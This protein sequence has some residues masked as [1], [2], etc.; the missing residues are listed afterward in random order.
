MPEI[1]ILEIRADLLPK[2]KAFMRQ[3]LIAD[4]AHFG[5]TPHDD[6]H[7][8]FPTEGTEDSFT[9]AAY[10]GDNMAGVVSFRRNG[11]DREKLRH[12]GDLFRMYVSPKYR[13]KGISKLLIEHLLERVKQL[14]GIEQITLFVIAENTVARSLYEK[15]GFKTYGIEPNAI[16]WKGKY[17]GKELMVRRM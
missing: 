12:K 16:K 6:E 13:G 10:A 14:Q 4:E 15:F 2:Y 5:I 8:P 1:E 3:G 9:L 11:K 17:F 7:A